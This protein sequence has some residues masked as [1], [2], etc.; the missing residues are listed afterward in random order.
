MSGLRKN[1]V[2]MPELHESAQLGTTG[3]H[4]AGC[5]KRPFRKAAAIYHSLRGGWDGPNCARPTR[6]FGGRALREHR[7]RPS[8]PALFFSILLEIQIEELIVFGREVQAGPVTG[9][10]RNDAAMFPA[11]SG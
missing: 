8:Y 6:A 5:S 2:G 4:R 9:E 10:T 3:V 1:C 11:E 7:D